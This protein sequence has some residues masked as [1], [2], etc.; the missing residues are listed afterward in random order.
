MKKYSIKTKRK[1]K[2]NSKNKAK[3]KAKKIINKNIKNLDKLLFIL[4]DIQDNIIQKGGS[5]LNTS[6]NNQ[7]SQDSKDSQDSQGSQGSQVSQDIDG[8]E[9]DQL[10]AKNPNDIKF[11]DYILIVKDIMNKID[12]LKKQLQECKQKLPESELSK[13]N[14]NNIFKNLGFDLSFKNI[15]KMIM[16]LFFILRF[17]N[18]IIL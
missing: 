6:N 17:L 2:K 10:L 12:L 1:A 5:E 8:D 16:K 9:I 7:D 4:D 18:G 11:T 3:N 15:I 13:I 14:D